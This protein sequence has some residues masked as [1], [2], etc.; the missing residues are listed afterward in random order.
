M[1][2]LENLHSRLTGQGPE[3]I[4]EQGLFYLLRILARIYVLV[5]W[6][7]GLTFNL[8]LRKI[9]HSRLPV[10]AVGNLAVGGTGK[11]PMV[12]L[13]IRYLQ[14]QGLRVAV[15]SRGYRGKYAGG[16]GIVSLGEGLLLSAEEAGDEP[17]LL[18]HRNPKAIVLVAARRKLA[19]EYIDL[20]ECADLIILDDAFQHRQVA[21]DLNLVLLDAKQP[22]GNQFLLPAGILRERQSALARADLICLT[23]AEG[24][25][26]I[27]LANKP[28]MRMRSTLSDIARSL[29][30]ETQT[31]KAFSGMKVVAFAGIGRPERFF[32]ALGQAGISTLAELALG[33]HV[34]YDQQLLERINASAIDAEILLTTEKDAVKLVADNFDLPCYAVGLE[35][36][37]DPGHTLYDQLDL[38][39][40]K[41]K[42]MP[43]S[44]ELLEILACPK[45]K[46]Q[47]TLQSVD[48]SEVIACAVCRLA[49][50]VRDGI[51]V[52]LIDEAIALED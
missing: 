39:L 38:L 41:D 49:Y 3:G 36:Y 32:S 24:E 48:A 19:L 43:L 12:D 8:G 4:F 11:T 22:F 51:P 33:D 6:L 13:L 37:L 47:V 7:R 27:P 18:A 16:A 17:C 44:A 31:L 9:Y 52:M 30:G 21:R 25:Y 50:P 5:V 1:N 45:C 29:T 46:G 2:K 42:T 10:I 14:R 34:L 26:S 23:G 20:H 28:V 35:V 40:Q 15:V